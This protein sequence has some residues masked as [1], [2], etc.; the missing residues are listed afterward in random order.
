E[1]DGLGVVPVPLG[2]GR[3]EHPVPPQR[4]GQEGQPV[5]EELEAGG[6]V[7]ADLPGRGGRVEPLAPEEH[8]PVGLPG[9]VR[10]G[11]RGPP[12]AG[13]VGLGQPADLVE[14]VPEARLEELG[15]L[16]PRRAL[17]VH[18]HGA[19]VEGCHD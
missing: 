15:R 7:P 13:G 2:V 3:V 12:P 14:E 11:R 19:G 10:A 8:D 16:V 5:P 17:A 4:Q 1:P 6:P 9:Q 18:R